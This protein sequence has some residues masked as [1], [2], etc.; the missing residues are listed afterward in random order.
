MKNTRRENDEVLYSSES[1]VTLDR[2]NLSQMKQM[3]KLN[4]RHRIRICTHQ[5][6]DDDVHEMIIYHPKDTYVP[7]HMHIGKD[8][9][10][11]LISGEIILILF[12]EY[13]K[14]S[15]VLKMGE[16]NT[17]NTFYYK[18]PA[19]TY[20]TQIFKQNT[21]FHEVTRGPFDKN[22]SIIATWAPDENDSLL[23]KEYLKK[24][25]NKYNDI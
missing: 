25:I 11:H 19:G 3:A 22:D 10:F 4:T 16:Y 24:I 13:G 1:F 5:T 8:E 6:I 18:I 14:I 23:V 21:F 15:K 7:P 12:N 2:D 20:H 17:G 9:S